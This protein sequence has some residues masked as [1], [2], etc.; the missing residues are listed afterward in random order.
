M[1]CYDFNTLCCS[2]VYFTAVVTKSTLELWISY[3]NSHDFSLLICNL[4]M[5]NQ[6]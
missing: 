1:D 5:L 3:Q 4:W 2:V 6:L